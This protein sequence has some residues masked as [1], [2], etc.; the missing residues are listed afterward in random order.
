MRQVEDAQEL[1][2]K[3]LN[4]H[5]DSLCLSSGKHQEGHDLVISRVTAGLGCLGSQL[6]IY[7]FK[8]IL[9]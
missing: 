9:E 5:Q 3:Q 7:V 8:V 1:N 6:K 4:H 2:T